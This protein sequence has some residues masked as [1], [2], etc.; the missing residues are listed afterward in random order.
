MV[1]EHSRHQERG[2]DDAYEGHH[3]VTSHQ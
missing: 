3:G 2:E 1:G